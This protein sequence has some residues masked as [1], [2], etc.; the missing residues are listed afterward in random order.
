VCQG[1]AL[2]STPLRF[3]TRLG[4]NIFFH[5]RKNFRAAWGF[6]NLIYLYFL[7]E[8][9]GKVPGQW[10]VFV[11]NQAK[12]HEKCPENVKMRNEQGVCTGDT[13]THLSWGENEKKV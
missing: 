12:G 6:L 9:E 13:Q 3:H 10:C 4:I 1:N 5:W 11:R 8:P 2:Q 7:G